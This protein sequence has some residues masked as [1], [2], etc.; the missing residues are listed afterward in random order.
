M[1]P[2]QYLERSHLYRRVMTN[3]I[4]ILYPWQKVVPLVQVVSYEATEVVSTAL[5]TIYVS[6]YT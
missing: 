6:P 5:F 1:N 2:I 4:S 3:I